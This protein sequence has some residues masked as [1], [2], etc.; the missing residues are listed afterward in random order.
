MRRSLY[1]FSILLF[2]GFFAV[3]FTVYIAHADDATT[4]KSSKSNSSERQDSN[5]DTQRPKNCWCL[6][7]RGDGPLEGICSKPC[8]CPGDCKN[9]SSSGKAIQ[10]VPEPVEATTVKNSKSNSSE[11]QIEPIPKP[12]EGKTVKGS[13]SN[14]SEGQQS[15][16][17]LCGANGTSTCG[18]LCER[19]GDIC[20][21]DCA[22]CPCACTPGI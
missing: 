15:Q 2:L 12:V 11:R 19:P 1:L 7:K 13:K 10:P 8:R 4:V 17:L 20:I 21:Q 9:K 6:G 18:G 22:D 16:D 3:H 14:T 5:T